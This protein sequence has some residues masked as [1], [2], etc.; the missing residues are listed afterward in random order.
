MVGAGVGGLAAALRLQHAGHR[1]SVLEQS[2]AVGGKL[3]TLEHDGFVFDTGPSLVTMPHI[4]AELF[5]ATGAPVDDVLELQ[6]LPIAA[7]YRFPDGTGLDLPGDFAEIPAALDAALGAGCGAQWSGFLD[8]ARRIW[9]AT[10]GPFLEAPI[11][12][13][14]MA[15][16]ARSVDDMRTVAPW[17][18]LR[19]LASRYLR[20]PRLRMMADRY[21]TYT[22]SDPRRA[23]AALASVP[24]AEQRWGSWYVRGGLGRIAVGLTD[25]LNALGGHIETGTAV[26]EIRVRDGRADG[27][28]TASGDLRRG[29]GGRQR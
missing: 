15:S 11:S 13:R 4:L 7:R 16:L 2:T 18:S 24:W 25:R 23:P 10:H 27:V 5:A 14:D 8:R 19:G 12:L 20:D 26:R 22:G 29:S 1:V 9:D 6:R 21:A 3:G 17:S 28:V